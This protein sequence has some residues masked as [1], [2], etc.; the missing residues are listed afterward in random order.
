MK[1]TI[2][3]ILILAAILSAFIIFKSGKKKK[4]DGYL[5]VKSFTGDISSTIDTT[6]DV[7]PMNRI[8]VK[9]SVAGRVDKLLV[10]EGGRVRAGQTLAMM[11]SNDRVAILDAARSKGPDELKYWQDTY[12]P[13]RVFSPLNG[14]VIF[15]N[16]VEGQTI[17]LKTVLFAISDNLIVTANVDESDIGRIQAGQR[18]QITLDAYPGQKVSGTVFQILHEGRNINNIITYKVKIKPFKVPKYFKSQM[19]ANILIE[20]AKNRDV[21]LL[22]YY[23]VKENSAGEQTVITGF[24]NGRP[25]RAFVRT[26]LEDGNNIEIVAGLSEN[27]TVH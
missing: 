13:V 17:D 26:G 16:V 9:S 10:D 7:E 3:I 15:R 27:E 4:S 22:P 12:K 2:I 24:E 1:K 11:S 18:A 23:A 20:V 8:E 5:P 21:L 6:G 14:T 25:V 19:T